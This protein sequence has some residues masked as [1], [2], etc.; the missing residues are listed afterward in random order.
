MKSKLKWDVNFKSF[1][2][3]NATVL[4]LTELPTTVN[5]INVFRGLFLLKKKSIP[6]CVLK[7]TRQ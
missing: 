6:S 7:S 4:W 3:K 5:Y 2:D 1:S